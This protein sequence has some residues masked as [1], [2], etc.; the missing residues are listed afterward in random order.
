[1]RVHNTECKQSAYPAIRGIYITAIINT[2]DLNKNSHE[3][4]F[5]LEFK[6][7]VRRWE[8]VITEYY[9]FAHKK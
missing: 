7:P 2:S 6:T 5:I 1:M 3:Y 4:D 8:E 9:H